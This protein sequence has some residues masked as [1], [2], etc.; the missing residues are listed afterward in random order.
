MACGEEG[1]DC[2]TPP[3]Q[4]GEEEWSRLGRQG[5]VEKKFITMEGGEMGTELGV[6]MI[7][8]DGHNSH[9]DQGQGCG[10]ESEINLI[11]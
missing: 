9:H 1:E 10:G 6:G 5:R 8:L 4:P 2:P 3:A 7:G 11:R